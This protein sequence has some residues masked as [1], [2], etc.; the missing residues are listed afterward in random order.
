VVFHSTALFVAGIYLLVVA[1]AGYWV[2][3]SGGT[4]GGTLQVTFVFAALLFLAAL[5]LSGSLRG[6]L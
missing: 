3:L 2:R 5:A 1:A 6:R 4:W